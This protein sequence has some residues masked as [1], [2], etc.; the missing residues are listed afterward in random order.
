[1]APLKREKG[2]RAGVELF[3]FNRGMFMTD[4]CNAAFGPGKGNRKNSYANKRGR[5]GASGGRRFVAGVCREKMLTNR[6]DKRAAK[7]GNVVVKTKRQY[8]K[9]K[10]TAH[11][12]PGGK[13]E[14]CFLRST[15]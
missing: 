14:K 15:I 3:I 7:G 8:G 5:A 13:K 6:S 1:M 11:P 9:A 12:T 10:L 4:N 2:T